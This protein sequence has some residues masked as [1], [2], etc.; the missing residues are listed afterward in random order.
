MMASP[1]ER[2]EVSG[3]MCALESPRASQGGSERRCWLRL[4]GSLAIEEKP[5]QRPIL[6]LRSDRIR[7]I[8]P[9]AS[10]S[11]EFAI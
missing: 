9:R 1:E 6:R 10:K 7:K 4:R 5:L 8:F 3:G 2:G 11:N